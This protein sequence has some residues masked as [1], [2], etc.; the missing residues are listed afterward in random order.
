MDRI[1]GIPV[2]YTTFETLPEYSDAFLFLGKVLKREERAKTLARYGRDT[3]RDIRTRVNAI[4]SN[5]RPTVYYAEDM[6]G[7]ATE[8]TGSPHAELIELAGARNVARCTPRDQMGMETISLE[9]VIYYDP[10]VIIVKER[11]FY[12]KIFTDP[13]WKRIKAVKTKRVYLI[14]S[15]PFNWFDRPPS[16]MRYMGI[17]WLMGCLYPGEYRK[18]TVKEAQSFYRL[19]LGVNPTDARMRAVITP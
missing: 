13:G 7:L 17:Q 5:R 16:F 15:L 9:K 8:C 14:P 12:D 1:L 19:F 10:E 6:D 2:V 11:T 3:L 18:D 4:P